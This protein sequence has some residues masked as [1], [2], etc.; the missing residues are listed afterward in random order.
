MIFERKI[1][2]LHAAKIGAENVIRKTESVKID[3][4]EDKE[5]WH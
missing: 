1:L 5:P 4:R 2:R 3:K